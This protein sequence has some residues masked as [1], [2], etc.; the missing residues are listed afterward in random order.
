M[1][2]Q[3]PQ[4]IDV[5]SKIVGPLTLRQFL[6]LAAAGGASF[7]LFFILATWLWFIITAVLVVIGAALAFVKYNG[8]PLIKI[9]LYAFGFLWKPR[10]YLW[11][12]EIKERTIEIPKI[13]EEATLTKRENLKDFFYNM[14]SVNKLWQN[15][16]TTKAPI[17]KRE[18]PH[19]S[20]KWEKQPKERFSVFKKITGDRDIARRVDYR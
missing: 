3:I 1:Q 7:M 16:M 4:F 14:P 2:F 10:L 9:I 6:Y 13:M 15:I 11:Q 18:K 17:P 19:R 5:E 8:Q 12:R 20:L